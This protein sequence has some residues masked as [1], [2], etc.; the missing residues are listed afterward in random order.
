MI[1]MQHKHTKDEVF[2]AKGTRIGTHFLVYYVPNFHRSDFTR[3]PGNAIYVMHD[4]ILL[5]TVGKIEDV[6]SSN[7]I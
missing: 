1:Y 5:Y 4:V 6:S 2:P 7:T 3:L